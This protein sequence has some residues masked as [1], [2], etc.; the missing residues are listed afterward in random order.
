MDRPPLRREAG[1]PPQPVVKPS[2]PLALPCRRSGRAGGRAGRA[3]AGRRRAGRL[4]GGG[5]AGEAPILPED[6]QRGKGRGPSEDTGCL[7]PCQGYFNRGLRLSPGPDVGDATEEGTE[8][9]EGSIH[10]L[11]STLRV[12]TQHRPLPRPPALVRKLAPREEQASRNRLTF[13]SEMAILRAMRELRGNILRAASRQ[14]SRAVQPPRTPDHRRWPLCAPAG[15][16]ARR[17]ASGD[18]GSAGGV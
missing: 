17:S 1:R 4:F 3:A 9:A 13:R 2:G 12:G 7:S 14:V 18:G 16:P 10:P 8:R 15:S 6:E 5:A 11:V